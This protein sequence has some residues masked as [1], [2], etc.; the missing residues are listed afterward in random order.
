M[1][2]TLSLKV[3]SFADGISSISSDIILYHSLK[4]YHGRGGVKRDNN[5]KHWN[6]WNNRLHVFIIII[7]IIIIIVIITRPYFEQPL[8]ERFE[9]LIENSTVAC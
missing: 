1:V 6:H 2:R 5:D 9:S 8:L 4:G 7:I 3:S